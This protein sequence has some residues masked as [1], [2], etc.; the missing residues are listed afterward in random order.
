MLGGVIMSI[1][2]DD[3]LKRIETANDYEINE[4]MEAVRCRFA[5]AFPDWEVLYLSCP[6]NDS[7]QRKQA[8]EILTQ[9]FN[10]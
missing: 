5:V 2:L 7:V 3:V 9:Y 1:S 4:I 10:T 8:L 6:K